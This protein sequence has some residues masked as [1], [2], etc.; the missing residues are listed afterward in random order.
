MQNQ[1]ITVLLS[2][3][4]INSPEIA[5]VLPTCGTLINER[6]VS[7]VLAGI[8]VS[9]NYNIQYKIGQWMYSNCVDVDD[10]IDHKQYHQWSMREDS[11]CQVVIVVCVV[12]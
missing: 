6:K 11:F 12:V 1:V 3:N 9:K 2:I 8:H 10:Y 4:I 5:Y 7:M